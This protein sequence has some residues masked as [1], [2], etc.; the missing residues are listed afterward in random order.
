MSSVFMLLH[1]F[2]F[3][4]TYFTLPFNELFI[5]GMAFDLVNQCYDTVGLVI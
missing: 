2:N 1:T 4:V 5:V 3:F